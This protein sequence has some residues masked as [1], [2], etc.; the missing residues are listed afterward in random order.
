METK[1]A[2]PVEYHL[3]IGGQN[4]L[5]NELIN[6]RIKLS[7]NDEIYCISCG[8]K[9][10]K[11][12]AQGFCYKCLT[13][14]PEADDCV[15]RPEMCQAH[16]G[17]SRDM[18]WSKHHCLE[19]HIVYLAISS[20]LK[21][22]V[23]RRSQVPTRWIDQGAWKAIKLALTPN[24][25][26]AGCIEVALKPFVSDKTSWQKMLKNSLPL[27]INLIEEKQKIGTYLETS[28]QQYIT[29]DDLIMEFSYP[30]MK[31]PTQK[32]VSLTFDKTK[33]VEKTL[34]GIKGQYLIFDDGCVLNIRKHN[35]YKVELSVL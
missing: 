14:A 7:Y 13:T 21:V 32:V 4:L 1:A 31:Y 16:L 35:G 18:E 27:K 6:K 29:D 19:E 33:E 22:G 12:F 15:L 24:R 8:A 9:T 17:I 3:R 23:T 28:L 5:M 20:D 26:L 30:V 25:Y 11:S 2:T 10:Y 34:I